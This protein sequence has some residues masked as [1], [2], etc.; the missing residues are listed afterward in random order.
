MSPDTVKNQPYT[1][2]P[3][4]ESKKFTTET[5]WLQEVKLYLGEKPQGGK[6]I[7]SLL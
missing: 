2:K 5:T 4:Q 3:E 1:E 6:K 7:K